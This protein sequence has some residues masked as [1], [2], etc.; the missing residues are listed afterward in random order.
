[1]GWDKDTVKEKVDQKVSAASALYT[2]E[3]VVNERIDRV[4][5]VDSGTFPINK[6]L[7]PPFKS[8]GG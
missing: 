8:F 5:V 7:K 2:D 1:M 4:N 6:S 3:I